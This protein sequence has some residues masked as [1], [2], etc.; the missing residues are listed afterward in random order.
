MAKEITYKKQGNGQDSW[1]IKDGNKLP[2]ISYVDPTD[3]TVKTV[4][5]T[6]YQLSKLMTLLNEQIRATTK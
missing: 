3:T 5:L 6:D 4:K 1:I 2:E